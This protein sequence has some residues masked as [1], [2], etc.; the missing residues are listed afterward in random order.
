MAEF[1]KTYPFNCPYCGSAKI[2]K[3]DRHSG[4]QRYR[5]KD[6]SKQFND[7]GA[8][9]G[10]HAT[11]EQIDMAVRMYY[12]GNSYKQTAET[13]AYRALDRA[14]ELSMRFRNGKGL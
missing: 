7:T 14:R 4:K 9:G 11:A 1:T 3:N 6:C 10:R 12:G 5:C 13:M 2:V 8:V